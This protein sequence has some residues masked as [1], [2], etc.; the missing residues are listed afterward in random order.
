MPDVFETIEL[1]KVEYTK[2]LSRIGSPLDNHIMITLDGIN[3]ISNMEHA[4]QELCYGIWSNIKH[5]V[6]FVATTNVIKNGVEVTP[7]Y[8]Y[9]LKRTNTHK[10]MCVNIPAQAAN[11][12]N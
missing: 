3:S 10:F 12:L 11:L 5:G 4:I 7:S 9:I 6:L 8:H 1:N 2:A